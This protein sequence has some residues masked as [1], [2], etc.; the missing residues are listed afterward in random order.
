MINN[1][2]ELH[3]TAKFDG[4]VQDNLR[5]YGYSSML[6]VRLK[7]EMGLVT[8]NGEAKPL[9][10]PVMAGDEIRVLLIDE[11]KPRPVYEHELNI[12]YE[13]EDMAI[14]DKTP[15]VAVIE[16]MPHYGKS[17][18]NILQGVWGDFVYRPINRLDR[19]TSGLMAVA[20]NSYVHSMFSTKQTPM[21]REYY[22]IVEGITDRA[23]TINAPIDKVGDDTVRRMVKE[24]GK[25]A[26][27]EY[28]TIETYGN[29]SLLR[30]RL[31]TGRTHQIRVHCAYIGHPLIGDDM[32]GGPTGD[33]ERHAL[34]S[35]YMEFVH[36]ITGE[37][38]RFSSRMPYD[39]EMLLRENK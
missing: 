2:R 20:K 26:I 5:E 16:T 13:D 23:G 1:R 36:P 30:L 17:L 27:T 32:Y 10:A 31:E 35:C 11:P 15:D 21:I 25:E 14:I 38:K 3:Y 18:A 33:I 29:R 8:V 34:H 9:I 6:I 4:S 28:T 39:M 37:K 22:A 24:G 19:Q 7:K 12:V